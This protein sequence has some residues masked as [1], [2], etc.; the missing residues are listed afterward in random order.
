MATGTVK[1]FNERKGYGFIRPDAGEEDLFVHRS[2]VVDFDRRGL[3]EGASVGDSEIGLAA[4]GAWVSIAL[5]SD[6]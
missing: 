4:G 1:W 3:P 2:G 5:A 6:R